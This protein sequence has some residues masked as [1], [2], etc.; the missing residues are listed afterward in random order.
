MEEIL[1]VNNLNAYYKKRI[2]GRFASERVHILKDISFSMREGEILG[3][4]GESGCG[5]STLAKTILHMVSDYNGEIVLKDEHPQMVFQDPF[6]SLNPGKTV[7][8]ILEEPLRNLTGMSPE[9]RR[10]KAEEM[11]SRVGLSEKYMDHL[12][13]ELSGGQRQRVCI[14]AS[15]MIGPKLLIADEP[16]SALDVTVQA[17]V[18]D[19][20]MKLKKELGLSILFISHDLRVVYKL[21]DRVIVMKDG[22]IQEMGSSRDV[23]FNPKS[24]YTKKLLNAAGIGEF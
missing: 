23:Y 4:V 9:K 2:K 21:C 22:K 19:L 1:T 18:I 11:L 3:L 17:Q 13:G 8:F 12:P 6:M 15:L 24:D 16:V 7:G 20:L 10:E 5:K 14:A